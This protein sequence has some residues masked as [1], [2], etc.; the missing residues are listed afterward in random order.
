M[1]QC[2][3]LASDTLYHCNHGNLFLLLLLLLCTNVLTWLV[4]EP[5]SKLDS[6]QLSVCR[7]TDWSE[8]FVIYLR[9][10]FCINLCVMFHQVTA[11]AADFDPYVNDMWLSRRAVLTRFQQA[12]RKVFTCNTFVFLLRWLALLAGKVMQSVMSLCLSIFFT[13]T[14]ELKVPRTFRLI[15]SVCMARWGTTATT[16]VPRLQVGERLWEWSRG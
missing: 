5:G 9:V 13:W 7:I 11:L 4:L 3:L 1:W 16:R 12:A 10:Y 2:I 15:F 6:L 8:T 14:F